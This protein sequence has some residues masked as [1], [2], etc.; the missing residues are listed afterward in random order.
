MPAK[1]STPAGY[2]TPRER[3]QRF[4]IPEPKLRA[5]IYANK[6]RILRLGKRV[7]IEIDQPNPSYPSSRSSWDGEFVHCPPLVN[8]S[9]LCTDCNALRVVIGLDTIDCRTIRW[10]AERLTSG[11]RL[12]GIYSRST[13]AFTPSKQLRLAA[14]LILSASAR[15]IASRLNDRTMHQMWRQKRRSLCAVRSQIR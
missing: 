7:F 8:S 12:T 6:L 11:D 14:S 4:G 2:E 9:L 10:V 5:Q 13:P 15:R 3:A 1:I